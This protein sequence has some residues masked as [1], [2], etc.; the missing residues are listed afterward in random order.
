MPIRN[1]RKN[2]AGIQDLLLGVGTANQSRGDAT[3]AMTKIDLPIVVADTVE[4]AALDTAD[5]TRARIYINQFAYQDY[6]LD[7]TATVGVIAPDSG[8]GYWLFNEVITKQ[9]AADIELADIADTINT[10]NKY[11]GKMVWDSTNNRM[12]RAN[13]ALAA[14]VWHVIDGSATV[15]PV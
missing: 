6:I 9:T 2:L 12:V 1:I 11:E 10:S 5:Y 15:T 4:L 14:D 3:V 8:L 7:P 13:G